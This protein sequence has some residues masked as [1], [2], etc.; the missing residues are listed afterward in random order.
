[1][2][3][4]I[5]KGGSLHDVA[6]AIHWGRFQEVAWTYFRKT[7]PNPI[8]ND[9]AEKLMAFML[10][11]VSHQV[12]NLVYVYCLKNNYYRVNCIHALYLFRDHIMLLINNDSGFRR[13]LA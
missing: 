8:G 1:M 10:G 3:S 13:I 4:P 9:D 2:Y 6:E 5:C 11:I 7:Y 12:S